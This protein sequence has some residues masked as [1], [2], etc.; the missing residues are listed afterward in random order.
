MKVVSP[1]ALIRLQS[2]R[3]VVTVTLFFASGIG[4]TALCS[5]YWFWGLAAAGM[6]L[7]AASFLAY[8]RDRIL[9]ASIIAQA[10]VLLCGFLTGFAHRDG[11]GTDDLR[12]LV[13]N[14]DFPLDEPVLF[15]GRI[16]EGSPLFSQEIL[17]VVEIQRFRK[18]S[19]WIIGKGRGILRVAI[20]D[21]SDRRK[22]QNSLV[23]GAALRSWAVWKAPINFE[24]PGSID[25]V[26][27][28]ARRGIFLT[29]R[30]KS[31][32]LIE[33]ISQISSNPLIS[34]V[35]SV[36]KQVRDT[37][38][39]VRDRGNRQAAA[40]LACVLIGDHSALDNDTREIFQ[41]TGSFH[42]LVVSGLHVAWIAGVW[43][44]VTG[45]IG[46]S[47]RFRHLSA[48]GIIFLYAWTVGFQAGITR[49][50]WM[51]LLYLTGRLLL[52]STDAVNIIF[53]AAL[54]LL[55]A[56]PDRLYET[57]FQLSFLSVSAIALTAVPMINRWLKPSLNPLKNAGH[58]DRF[59]LDPGTCYR[60]GRKLRTH[61]ELFA[62]WA[63]DTLP[64]RVDGI[65]L[66]LSRL[67]AYAAFAIGS[68]I[69]LSIAVQIWIAPL[70]ALHFN[71]ISWI[72]PLSNPVIVPLASLCLASGIPAVLTAGITTIG[73]ALA[74]FA[75]TTATLL[76]SLAEYVNGIAGAWQR[77]PTPPAPCV[78]AVILLLL[79][80]K[81]FRWKRSWIPC[82]FSFL[83]LAV[84][85][86]GSSNISKI[87][88]HKIRDIKPAGITE[89]RLK[90]NPHLSLTF[91]D[92]GEGDSIIIRFPNKALW[93]LDAG[94]LR[95]A[96][97]G[98]NDVEGFDTGEAVV[99]RYL[100]HTWAGNP[101]RVLL[102]HTDIDHA[103]GIP[104]LLKNFKVG[105]LAYPRCSPDP[106]LSGILQTA[107]Q[108]KVRT[109]PINAGME[110]NV[111]PVTVRILH[112]QPHPAGP[113]DNDHSIVLALSFRHFTALLTGDLGKR[114]EAELL[115]NPESLGCLLLKVAHHGSRSATSSAFLDATQP[116]WAVVS[117][118]RDNPFGHPSIEVLHRLNR[119]GVRAYQTPNEGAITFTTDGVDYEIRSHI[120]GLLERGKLD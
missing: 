75:I 43:L 7:T 45:F 8:R 92:V 33:S 71:R 19:A 78:F 107:R 62:E 64:V 96:S 108:R 47:E 116:Q 28:L 66:L 55:A 110:E 30:I 61:C 9:Q 73:P 52:R 77:C 2:D 53:S 22:L 40:I 76:N 80:W 114:G 16:T 82:A 50:L 38:E 104:A 21:P 42:I 88:V 10:A 35:N 69:L 72:A 87:L 27:S 4:L 1:T 25:R 102:S 68:M 12:Q 105:L 26:S 20:A 17:V 81:F 86:S 117:A 18:K 15:E 118:G 54:I 103:G 34:F 111:G 24:N 70:I 23:P 63:G 29:G 37:L 67:A 106:I 6:L 94:G 36:R 91:L 57:G 59:F 41:N 97:S 120:N 100:W 89:Q 85:A 49:C 83:L 48:A 5:R 115:A 74:Q 119:K 60:W 99:S 93:V 14:Q 32:M 58:T 31:P 95:R 65:L 3:P 112:P 56:H 44:A 51:F 113:S 84:T 46:V 79:L 39:P 13:C 11:H 90:K 101:D 109:D 98:E